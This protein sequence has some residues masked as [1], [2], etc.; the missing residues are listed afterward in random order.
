ME[1]YF[2]KTPI[3]TLNEALIEGT[4]G[5]VKLHFHTGSGVFSRNGID[6][7]SQLLIESFLNDYDSAGKIILDLGCGY[8]PIGIFAAEK[9]RDAHI[10]MTDINE[11]AVELAMKNADSNKLRNI[12]V[13][14]SDAF[15]NIKRKY[16][17]I[18]TNP[19]IRAGKKT[20][21]SFYEGAFQHL[22]NNG[23][24]YCVIQKKQGA[25]SSFKK[26]EELFGNCETINRKSGYRVL[27]SIK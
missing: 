27:K 1:H 9:F 19:P 7:G 2:N 6:F 10:E 25:E 23:S 14:V 16:D 21:F 12:E 13:Y 17:A 26:L 5:S 22:K 11:R 15:S 20:V 4:I 3:S 24:F 8:G 18:V